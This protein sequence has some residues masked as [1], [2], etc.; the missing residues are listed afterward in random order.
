MSYIFVEIYLSRQ[1]SLLC[2]FTVK[3]FFLNL[4]LSCHTESYS[5]VLFYYH[6]SLIS[7]PLFCLKQLQTLIFQTYKNNSL[8]I[9]LQN[10]IMASKKCASDPQGKVCGRMFVA[11]DTRIWSTTS[12]PLVW[13]RFVLCCD[14][15]V[16]FRFVSSLCLAL[17][18]RIMYLKTLVATFH[19]AAN[20]RFTLFDGSILWTGLLVCSPN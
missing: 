1:P 11:L 10:K 5:A 19:V 6:C 14:Y 20:K 2:G 3:P 12:E 7:F 13:C 8:E 4:R 18:C 16:S 17:R 15:F 9:I